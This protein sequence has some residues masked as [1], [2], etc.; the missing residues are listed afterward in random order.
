M[1]YICFNQISLQYVTKVSFQGKSLDY[2]TFMYVSLFNI[3]DYGTAISG[4]LSNTGTSLKFT[5]GRVC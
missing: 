1:V 2:L 4:K 5:I 3:A